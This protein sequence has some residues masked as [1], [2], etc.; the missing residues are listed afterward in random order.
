[1]C[2]SKISGM[3]TNYCNFNYSVVLFVDYVHKGCSMDASES[4]ELMNENVELCLPMGMEYG[5]DGIMEINQQQQRE[6]H[7]RPPMTTRSNKSN[8]TE[9]KP[10][11]SQR[12]PKRLLYDD[13]P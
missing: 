2:A 9:S 4:D 10:T 11:H 7:Y 12:L 13:I 8:P 1:M 3:I 6:H 5:N